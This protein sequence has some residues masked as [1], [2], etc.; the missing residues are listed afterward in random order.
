MRSFAEP[1]EAQIRPLAEAQDILV[2]TRYAV[3]ITTVGRRSS[4]PDESTDM[5]GRTEDL[6]HDHFQ[7]F[8]F[9]IVDMHEDGAVI[10]QQLAQK[11]KRG[12]IMHNHLSCRD[13]SS[14]SPPTTCPS[15]LRISGDFTLS[16]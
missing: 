12:Y 11:D 4:F 8:N 13:K 2:I 3:Q 16:L 10:A 6:I 1:W 7:P 5:V 14:A 15:H 9:K